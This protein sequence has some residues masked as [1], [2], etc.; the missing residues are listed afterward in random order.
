MR[1]KILT[2]LAGAAFGA[3]ALL[4][5]LEPAPRHTAPIVTTSAPAR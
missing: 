2:L 3:A 4:F 1:K 5:L